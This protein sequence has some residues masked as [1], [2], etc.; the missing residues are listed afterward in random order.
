MRGW[1]GTCW[2]IGKSCRIGRLQKTKDSY[3]D[4]ELLMRR[5]DDNWPIKHFCFLTMDDLLFPVWK[6]FEN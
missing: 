3:V 4:I 1:T 2:E 5:R 6:G